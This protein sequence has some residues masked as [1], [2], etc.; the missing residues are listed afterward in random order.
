MIRVE[1]VGREQA[2]D[3]F[4]QPVVQ[5]ATVSALKKVASAARTVASE[6][7]R[8]KYNIK[9]SDLDPRIQM[10]QFRVGATVAQ[11]TISGK[12]VPLSYFGAKQ[13]AVNRTITRASKSLKTKTTKRS[14][15]FLGVSIE[16]EQGKRTQLKSAFLAQMANQHIGVMQ[17]LTGSTMKSRAKYAGTKHA[18]KLINKGVVSIATMVQNTGVEPAVIQRVNEAWVTTFPAE[19]NYLINVKGK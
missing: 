15:K 14:A 16:V 12:G 9:K 11:I 17:R 5:K 13:F 10:P 19:L 2:I 1:L 3:L 8:K 6:E 18:E 7:I 4:G